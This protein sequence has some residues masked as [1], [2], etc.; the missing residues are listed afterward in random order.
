[1]KKIVLAAALAVAVI[2]VPV[3]AVHAKQSAM[4]ATMLC[5]PAVG[6]EKPMAMMGSKGIEC[7]SMDSM[8][9]NGHMGPDVKGMTG[10]QTDAAWQA[11]IQQQML[12]QSNTGTTGGN[13]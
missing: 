13:G 6:G 11:W 10:A 8:M 12:I 9:K 1:M 5:R 7:K 4:N 3:L 2:S